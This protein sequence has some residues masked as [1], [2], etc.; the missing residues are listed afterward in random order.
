MDVYQI[1]TDRII[2]MLEKGT[3]PWQKPWEQGIPTNLVTKKPYR[4]INVFLLA[5]QRFKSP[6]W[7]TFRQVSNL[8]GSVKAGAKATPVVFWKLLSKEGK[9]E[10]EK[11][12]S[13]KAERGETIPLLRYYSVFNLEQTTGINIPAELEKVFSPIQ[14][15]EQ[16]VAGMPNRPQIQ[17]LE[18]RAYYHPEK[19]Y[20]NM[21]DPESFEEPEKYYSTIF[22]ELTHSTGHAT[23][24][25]RTGITDLCPFGETNYSKEELVAE[26]GAAF[27]CGTAGIANSTIDN[28]ASYISTWLNRLSNDKKLLICAAA[29]AQRATDYILGR[30]KLTT[31]ESTGGPNEMDKPVTL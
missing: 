16:I 22:H 1:I 25:S 4:G 14:E 6:Y 5:T 8:G 27:L 2:D 13:E 3:V 15:C 23:R 11:L 28:S 20:I 31:D 24:L 19:D 7:M 9:S 26:M 12:D 29:Q 18:S 10:T 21:P 17:H 30:S